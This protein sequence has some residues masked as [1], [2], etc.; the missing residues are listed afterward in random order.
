MKRSAILLLLLLPLTGCGAPAFQLTRVFPQLTLDRPVALIEAP[1][2][3]FY[4]VQQGGR[5]LTFIDGSNATV[6]ADLTDRVDAGYN[7]AGL[8]GM[9]LDPQ[10]AVNGQVYLS[11]TRGGSPLTSVVSRFTSHDGGLTLDPASEQPLLAIDQP[12]ANHNGGN[13]LFGP[14]G[15]LYLGFGDGGASG[16][17]LGNAQNTQTLLGAILRIDVASTVPYAIPPDNPFASSGGRPEIYAYGLRNPWR[18]SFDSQSGK[19]WAGDVGQNDWEEID[20]IVKGG[21]YG[22]PIREGNH[23]YGAASCSTSGFIAPL[24]EYSHRDGCSVTGGYVYRGAAIPSLRGTYLY[25]DYCSGSIWGLDAD[26]PLIGPA[27][28][29]VSSNL[30]ITSFAQDNAG[31][32]YV[33]DYGG[34]IWKLTR[35][36]D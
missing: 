33:L 26:S 14:D 21:N 20:L 1:A 17:P 22:W 6:F 9:A 5:I 15:Y 32:L 12:Y 7:E 24:A 13:L 35:F 2:G 23:C 18:F 31:E 30:R 10:F 4:V 11:Y 16:D 25:G 29:L 28:W 27:V 3:R 19:L 36:V 8:L 34:T